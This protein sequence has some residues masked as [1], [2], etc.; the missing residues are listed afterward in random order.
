MVKQMMKILLAAAAFLYAP[1]AVAG[2]EAGAASWNYQLYCA[3]CH[4]TLAN[5]QGINETYGGLSVS[6]RDHT[7]AKEMAKLSDEDLRLAISD[8]G[9]VV[10]KSGLMPAW[11][12]TLSETE[13]NG[14]VVY[15][16]TLCGCKAINR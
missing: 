13:I 6:P 7:S 5:G 11:A 9:E 14:L 12:N 1:S 15:L 8:G 2:T 3:Q 16:R 4:G 10:Q